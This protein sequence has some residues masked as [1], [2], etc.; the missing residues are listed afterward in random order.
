MTKAETYKVIS[1]QLR[2]V[3]ALMEEKDPVVLALLEPA[4][5]K[6]HSLLL[7]PANITPEKVEDL[8]ETLHVLD[9]IIAAMDEHGDQ[10]E[11][12]HEFFWKY[13]YGIHDKFIYELEYDVDIETTDADED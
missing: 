8:R 2:S 10:E 9:S 12:K 6:A 7:I 13:L 4:Y 1:A 11:V 3:V 5:S